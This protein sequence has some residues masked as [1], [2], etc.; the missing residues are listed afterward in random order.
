MRKNSARQYAVALYQTAK[1][2]GKD[3]LPKILNNF[4]ALLAKNHNL[5]MAKQIVK[6][7]ITHAKE[8]EGINEIEITSAKSLDNKTIEAIKKIFGDQVESRETI[9]KTIIG[10]I[11]IRTKDHILDASVK[12]QLQK[13]RQQLI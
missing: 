3:E 6:E 9:D 5:K 12:T 2:A 7:L 10:G 4:T 8:A 11:I 1:D 13:L